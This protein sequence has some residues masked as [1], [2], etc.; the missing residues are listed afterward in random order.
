MATGLRLLAYWSRPE[1]PARRLSLATPA[2]L[3]LVAGYFLSCLFRNVNGLV[4]GDIMH[5]LGIGAD[6]LGLLT[7][8]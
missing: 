2:L 3:P 7:S 8:V 4:A 6:A 1:V 5:D